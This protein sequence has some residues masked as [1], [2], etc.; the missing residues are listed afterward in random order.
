MLALARATP[1]T[2]SMS[3]MRLT[4]IGVVLKPPVGVEAS[5][6]MTLSL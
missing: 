3:W 1:G 2:L 5:A 4:A 6:I